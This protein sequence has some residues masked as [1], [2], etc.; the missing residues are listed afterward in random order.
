M[1]A[2]S[3]KHPCPPAS[4]SKHGSRHTEFYMDGHHYAPC[5]LQTSYIYDFATDSGWCVLF[6]FYQHRGEINWK[7][8]YNIS[9]AFRT[10]IK[11]TEN[12]PRT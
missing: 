12:I 10:P 11:L 5:V 8:S 2:F 3:S 1:L 7:T 9:T 4:N 6:I